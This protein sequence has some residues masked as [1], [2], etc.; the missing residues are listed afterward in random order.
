MPLVTAASLGFTAAAVPAELPLVIPATAAL[1]TG[2][3][4]D[5]AVVYTAVEG[6]ERPT[7]IGKEIV[8]GPRA[9]DYYIVREGLME[10]EHVVTRGNFKIDAELQLRGKPSLMSLPQAVPSAVAPGEQTLCPV[11]GTPINKEYFVEYKG[12]TVYFC[13][14]GCDA[15]FLADPEKYLPK[16]PQF[17]EES[18]TPEL[19]QESPQK[20][21]H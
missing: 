5:R 15:T 19:T 17:A 16:L 14:P 20:H 1:L 2:R 8:L 6:A 10:G 7:Y 13:C 11:M 12:K 18:K 4:L 21:V 9:G 3:K